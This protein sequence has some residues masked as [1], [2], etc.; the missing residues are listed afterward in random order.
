MIKDEYAILTLTQWTNAATQAGF[1]AYEDSSDDLE[2][3]WGLLYL[4]AEDEHMNT[5]R[6]LITDKQ[7]LFLAK[8]KYGI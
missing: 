2:E 8:I 7:K 1:D 3:S 4:G 5:Y 6:F